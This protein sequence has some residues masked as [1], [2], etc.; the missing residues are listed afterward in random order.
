MRT[1]ITEESYEASNKLLY[2]VSTLLLISNF[3]SVESDCAKT[4]E[5]EQKVKN[6]R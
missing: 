5:K 4:V 3:L 2:P 6:R 1:G